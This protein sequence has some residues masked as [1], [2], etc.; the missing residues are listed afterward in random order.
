[1]QAVH[2][3]RNALCGYIYTIQWT[4]RQGQNHRALAKRLLVARLTRRYNKCVQ[5]C[6]M[7]SRNKPLTR[8]K[9]RLLSLL[10]IP[11][12]PWE[13]IGMDF[14]THLPKTKAGYTAI[15]VVVDRLTE[16]V[17]I[18]HTTDTATA[19]DTTPLFLDMVFNNYGLPS[20]IVSN[21]DVKFT[22]SFWTAFCQ[23]VGIKL[24]MSTAYY[25]ETNGQT[26]RMNRV[27]VDMMRHYIR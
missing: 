17:H 9:A 2:S 16:L 11:C 12:R 15:Y 20:S 21:K 5:D 25:L 27:I 18:A 13:S 10:P 14:I 22:S 23:Q 19:A 3:D 6:E 7:C 26:K 8:K 4:C 24:K 1:M